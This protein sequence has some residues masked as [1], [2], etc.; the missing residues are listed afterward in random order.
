MSNVYKDALIVK[1]NSLL[2]QLQKEGELKSHIGDQVRILESLVLEEDLVRALDQVKLVLENSKVLSSNEI[3]N[4]V[5]DLKSSIEDVIKII[6]KEAKEQQMK[7][8]KQANLDV[9]VKMDKAP[10]EIKMSLK[11]IEIRAQGNEFKMESLELEGSSDISNF[12]ML[13]KG[14]M[15]KK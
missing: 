2:A 1:V 8:I 14:M 6:G 15:S 7:S 9:E 4:Q 10:S 3:V 13:I 11:G 5:Y 12:L